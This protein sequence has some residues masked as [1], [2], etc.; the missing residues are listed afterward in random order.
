M[1]L[2]CHSDIAGQEM[3]AKINRGPAIDALPVLPYT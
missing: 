1:V 3:G 2:L